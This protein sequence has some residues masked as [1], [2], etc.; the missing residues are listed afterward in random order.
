MENAVVHKIDL[1]PPEEFKT[2]LEH[3]VS[4][5]HRYGDSLTLIDMMV[6]ADPTGPEN[7]REAEV[8]AINALNLHL[9]NA[10]VACRKG[11]EFLILM[12]ATGTPGARTA[13]ERIR[14]LM[15]VKHERNGKPSFELAI[16]VGMATLPNEDQSVS[17]T[18]LA[19]NA[20]QALA[21]S[22]TNRRTNAVNF[23]E[24]NT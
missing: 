10:D 22:R 21:H 17:S 9:R 15:T 4:R 14:K 12:P 13:C 18:T 5:S 7:Q 11:N 8:S 19:Q 24:M 6:E 3:E 1:Y 20:S 23:T 2:I 16:Y